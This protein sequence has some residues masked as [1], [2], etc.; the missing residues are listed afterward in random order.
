MTTARQYSPQETKIRKTVYF[1]LHMTV[2]VLSIFLIVSISIAT[3]NDITYYNDPHFEIIQFWICILFLAD[4]AA[5]WIMSEKKW[6]YLLTHFIFFLVSI[7][8]GA[9]IH[10]FNLVFDP[11]ISYLMRYIPLVRGGYALIM[12]VNW[13]TSSRATGLF[14]SY[15]LTLVASVYFM[16]LTFLVF[17]MPV[18]PGVNTYADALWWACMDMTTVGCNIQP[19]TY[20]GKVL[21]FML[22]ALGM[23]LFPIFTVYIT[24]IIKSRNRSGIVV[25]QGNFI[26]DERDQNISGK[27]EKSN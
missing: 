18:N 3:F 14:V 7:P 9:I 8:Y 26:E 22:A 12:V 19:V 13:L 17:E 25:G 15:L 11:Q 20:V 6:H 24:S 10:H 27:T 5:E 1:W 16:S 21:A 2:L 23:M 4:F